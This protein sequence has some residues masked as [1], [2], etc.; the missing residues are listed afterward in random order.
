MAHTAF[1]CQGGF[2]YTIERVKKGLLELQHTPGDRE[3]ADLPTKLH[4]RARLLDLLQ[5][6]NMQG[7][8]EL[9]QRKVMGLVTLS[10]VL[11]AMMAMQSL[12]AEAKK[13]SEKEPL[14]VAG[15][16]ELSFVLA[17]SCL[18]AVV[19][20]E[21]LKCARSW[22]A[23]R[24]FQSERSRNLQRLRDLARMAAEA[25]IDR[26]WSGAS[27][28]ASQGVHERV[29]QAVDRALGD[30]RAQSRA[31]QT[32]VSMTARDVCPPRSVHETAPQ[33]SPGAQST[34]SE[35]SDASSVQDETLRQSDRGRLCRDMVMLMT[36]ESIKQGLRSEGLSLGG[37]KPELAQLGFFLRLDSKYLAGGSQPT[38]RCVMC[39]GCGSIVGCR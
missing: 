34:R 20:W 12:V 18:A 2:S 23:R 33:P 35:R 8:P 4:S 27:E 10:V 15:A 32:D 29:Q 14:E 5:L 31:V 39:Y 1:A 3:L 19:C 21:L 6:W 11:C 22:C 37:L 16:W 36:V 25:E 24:L 26:R 30:E 9:S 28:A 13:A 17:L 38:A 7:L